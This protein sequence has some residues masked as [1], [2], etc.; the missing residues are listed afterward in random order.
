MMQADDA[1][2]LESLWHQYHRS[3]AKFLDYRV[4]RDTVEDMV[5]DVFL[6]AWAAMRRGYG[7]RGEERAWLFQIARSVVIDHWRA[8]KGLP[9]LEDIDD[10]ADDLIHAET[11]HDAYERTVIRGC[12]RDSLRVLSDDQRTMIAMRLD[13][14][15]LEEIADEMGKPYGAIKAIQHRA[16]TRMRPQLQELVTYTYRPDRVAERTEAMVDT[17]HKRGPLTITEI[18]N[19]VGHERK[20]VDET[21]HER[22]DLFVQVGRSQARNGMAAVYGLVGI[23]DTQDT[24]AA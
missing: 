21:L 13:G 2:T 3:I 7:S 20:A 17:L 19:F 14:Y 16:Y 4:Q 6:R 18:F 10:M 22:A 1:A 23:H 5:Q 8:L 24:E 12:I 11:P 9:P 15:E